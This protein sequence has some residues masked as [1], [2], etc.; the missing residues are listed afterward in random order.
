VDFDDKATIEVHSDTSAHGLGGVFIKSNKPV[1][2]VSASMTES[3]G[4]GVLQ[5]ESFWLSNRWSGG[6]LDSSRVDHS[7]L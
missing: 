7:P 1:W 5:I 6:C 4:Y 3:H 2:C